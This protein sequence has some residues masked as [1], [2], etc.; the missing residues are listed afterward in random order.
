MTD[1]DKRAKKATLGD[2]GEL[3]QLIDD[4]STKRDAIFCVHCSTPNL[5]GAKFCNECGRSLV[6]QQLDTPLVQDSMGAKRKHDEFARLMLPKYEPE[7]FKP[8]SF[9]TI[10]ATIFLLIIAG[11]FLFPD[12]FSSIALYL[13]AHLTE[14]M[15][16]FI[17]V[18][19]I[20]IVAWL[21]RI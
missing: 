6:E 21:S 7:P 3:H 14:S 15:I 12:I 13:S 11:R 9:R 1:P 2:D 10:L 19:L 5:P 4:P 18:I 17:A 20:S 8:S 16:V